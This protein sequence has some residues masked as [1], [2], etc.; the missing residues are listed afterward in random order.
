M[1]QIYETK[2]VPKQ[3]TP[4]ELL[5]QAV[6]WAV[7]NRIETYE[8]LDE[9]TGPTTERG[10]MQSFSY[11]ETGE[12]NLTVQIDSTRQ[13]ADFLNHLQASEYIKRLN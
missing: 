7:N 10:F 2:A 1:R 3:E 6:T 12:M 11:Q 9:I 8:L 5:E 4:T 13:A